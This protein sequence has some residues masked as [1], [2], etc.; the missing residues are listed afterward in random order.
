MHDPPIYLQGSRQNIIMEIA[1]QY[2]DTYNE[3]IFTYAN[4]INTREG[5]THLSGFKAGLTRCINQYMA[6]ADLPKN[7]KE[8]H[9]AGDDVREGLTGIISIKFPDSQFERVRLKPS[10]ETGRSKVW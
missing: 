9:L 3:Q 6:T 2:N 8:Q 7:F 10:W 1:F 4:N 5:G